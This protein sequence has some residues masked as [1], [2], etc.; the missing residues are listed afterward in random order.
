VS[1]LRILNVPTFQKINFDLLNKKLFPGVIRALTFR[2]DGHCVNVATLRTVLDAERLSFHLQFFNSLNQNFSTSLLVQN[3]R[4]FPFVSSY[5]R[6]AKAC[7]FISFMEQS[8]SLLEGIS[9]HVPAS[10][11]GL[12]MVAIIRTLI[13]PAK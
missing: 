5:R 13:L 9:S 4:L 12:Q 2:R 1:N 3:G 7:S 11:G 8:S 10:F 6:L